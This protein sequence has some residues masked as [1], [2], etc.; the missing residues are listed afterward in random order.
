MALSDELGWDDSLTPQ[1]SYYGRV[2]FLQRYV[3]Q[4]LARFTA[5][6]PPP[7]MA[8][9]GARGWLVWYEHHTP[10]VDELAQLLERLQDEELLSAE[11]AEQFTGKATAE[12]IT[13]LLGVVREHDAARGRS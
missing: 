10:T 6:G 4:A 2:G 13:A 3:P 5:E 1:Q 11:Q 9:D 12:T 7:P 8:A